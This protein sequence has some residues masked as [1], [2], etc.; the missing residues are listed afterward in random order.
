MRLGLYNKTATPQVLAA[1][2]FTAAH[3]FSATSDGIRR[4]RQ[5]LR[6]LPEDELAKAITSVPDF[7]STSECRDLF[8][9]VQERRLTI[10]QLKGAVA[11]TQMRF[12]GFCVDPTTIGRYRGRFLEDTTQT[13]LDNWHAFESDNPNTFIRMYVFVVQKVPNLLN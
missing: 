12:L 13:N 9:H 11:Q 5:A 7:Y 6:A 3:G 4:A 1:R 8:F 10:P 2:A